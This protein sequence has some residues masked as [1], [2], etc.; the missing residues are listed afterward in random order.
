M[1]IGSG[2]GYRHSLEV[3][4]G[5]LISRF[6][7]PSGFVLERSRSF[8][9]RVFDSFH[10]SVHCVLAG[11]ALDGLDGGVFSSV[12]SCLGGITGLCCLASKAFS[13]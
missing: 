5:R 7:D 12:N 10:C 11:Y 13:R 2:F 1:P 3:R 9:D 4:L 8:G 6:G